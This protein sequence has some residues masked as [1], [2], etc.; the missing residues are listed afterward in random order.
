MDSLPAGGSQPQQA[1][2]LRLDA[3]KRIDTRIR[4]LAGSTADNFIKLLDLLAEAKQGQIHQAR[5]DRRANG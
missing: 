5:L 1:D 2:V 3:A 4:L